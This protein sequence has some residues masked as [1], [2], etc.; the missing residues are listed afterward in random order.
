MAVFGL[1]GIDAVNPDEITW[2]YLRSSL[3]LCDTWPPTLFR[4]LCLLQ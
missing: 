2:I 4:M 3:T 1:A